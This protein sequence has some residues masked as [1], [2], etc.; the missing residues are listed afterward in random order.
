MDTQPQEKVE[1]HDMQSKIK[2]M[3]A[4]ETYE[5]LECRF[6]AEGKIVSKKEVANKADDITCNISYIGYG[7]IQ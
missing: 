3:T 2:C 1:E 4:R 5:A 6:C 7:E